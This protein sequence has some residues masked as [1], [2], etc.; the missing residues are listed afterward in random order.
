MYSLILVVPLLAEQRLG[1][2]AGSGGL[3]LAAMTASMLVAGP[4]GGAL[5]DRVGRRAPVLA[6]G[7]LACGATAGMF[8][9]LPAPPPALLALL[10]VTVGLG[11]GLATAPVQAAAIE[12]APAG[13][14]GLAGGLHTMVRYAGGLTGS[15]LVAAF[16][17]GVSLELLLGMLVGAAAL[18]ILA[19]RGLPGP[20]GRAPAPAE[21][22]TVLS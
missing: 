10:L 16:G 19:S 9:A 2:G 13:A 18:G 4:A 3:I 11:M 15:G 7:V 12:A 20:A 1:L 17:S 22:K 14:T 5:S 6:G 21:V 8:A